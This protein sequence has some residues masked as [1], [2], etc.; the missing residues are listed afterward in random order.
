MFN[1]P[2]DLV[3][4]SCGICCQVMYNRAPLEDDE[5]HFFRSDSLELPCKFSK[6]GCLVYYNRSKICADYKC[7][8]A[9][10]L[11][12]GEIGML[13][14][15]TIALEAR[16]LIASIEIL[17]IPCSLDPLELIN[18]M[19]IELLNGQG[20]RAADLI[21]GREVDDSKFKKVPA[22]AVSNIDKLYDLLVAHFYHSTDLAEHG[23]KRHALVFLPPK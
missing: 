4:N 18:E 5:K 11:E 15:L 23:I 12:R 21:I 22:L 17:L 14:G 7:H 19:V 8:L 3:C 13:E 9:R 16:I 10:R 20:K 2:A 6:G 1:T